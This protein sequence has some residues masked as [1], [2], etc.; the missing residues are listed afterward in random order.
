MQSVP[1]VHFRCIARNAGPGLCKSILIHQGPPSSYSL[2]CMGAS[3]GAVAAV[4]A[5]TVKEGK[6]TRSNGKK[7]RS[8]SIPLRRFGA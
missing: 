1:L 5:E 7:L 6:F 4:G 2:L 8:P 3:G